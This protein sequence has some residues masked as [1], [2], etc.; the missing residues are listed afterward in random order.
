MPQSQQESLFKSLL[1]TI[2]TTPINIATI[3]DTTFGDL[4]H[5]TGIYVPTNSFSASQKI[6][7]INHC[8][9][10]LQNSESIQPDQTYSHVLDI[11]STFVKTKKSLALIP[12]EPNVKIPA[13]TPS[14]A[15]KSPAVQ[16]QEEPEVQVYK[17]AAEEILTRFDLR[18][19]LKALP[20]NQI[21][22]MFEALAM[23]M[24]KQNA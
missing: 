21:N 7:G 23:K 8:L 19:K 6:N 12:G 16:F 2:R 1:S 9:K 24:L 22:A 3:N 10:K 15:V 5:L 17:P 20:M 11:L 18:L 14:P 4:C 13:A